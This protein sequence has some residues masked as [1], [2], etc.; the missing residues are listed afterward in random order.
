MSR[1][2]AIRTHSMDKGE[3]KRVGEFVIEKDIPL[4]PV[5][6]SRAKAILAVLLAMDVGESFLHRVKVN[7]EAIRQAGSDRKYVQRCI[8]KGPQHRIWRTK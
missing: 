5:Q 4:P 8:G 6:Q 3:V 1:V 7:S 2:L